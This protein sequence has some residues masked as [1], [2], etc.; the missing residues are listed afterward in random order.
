MVF[1][2]GKAEEWTIIKASPKIKLMQEHTRERIIDAET[3]PSFCLSANSRF[4]MR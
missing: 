1:C 2:V 3:K 4:G